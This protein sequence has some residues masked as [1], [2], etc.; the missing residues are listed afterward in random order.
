[1]PTQAF[2]LQDFKADEWEAMVPTYEQAVE[3][4]KVIITEGLEIAMTRFN[5]R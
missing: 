2:L 5:S 1:M 3:A 4:I